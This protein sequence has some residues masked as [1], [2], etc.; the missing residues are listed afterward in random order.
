[1]SSCLR[2]AARI[3][4]R[5]VRRRR[6][7]LC[8]FFSVS[9]S[10]SWTWVRSTELQQSTRQP[11]ASADDDAPGRG[12]EFCRKAFANTLP[13]LTAA[14][15]TGAKLRCSLVTTAIP[16]SLS[17]EVW[18]RYEDGRVHI[19]PQKS[20]PC[21]CSS[22]HGGHTPRVGDSH[23]PVKSTAGGRCSEV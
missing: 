4:P 9:M 15:E 16:D 20:R 23:T 10:V 13:V 19:Q 7:L 14:F 6:A 1:M 2:T 12:E 22:R 17:V 11:P 18:Q 8:D 3:R 5:E 21:R